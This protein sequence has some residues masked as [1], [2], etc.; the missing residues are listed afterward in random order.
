MVM[1]FGSARS[2]NIL[3][4]HTRT[5]PEIRVYA[6][7]LCIFSIAKL[8]FFFFF[9][10]LLKLILTEK[11]LFVNHLIK[12]CKEKSILF[13]KKI[14]LW[15]L[16]KKKKGLG[17]LYDRWIFKK[18]LLIN[19]KNFFSKFICQKA[20]YKILNNNIKKIFLI[21]F[22]NDSFLNIIFL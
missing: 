7:L 19:W 18:K 11:L 17:K 16:F 21:F 10:F 2:T 22:S 3:K 1:L 9:Y 20:L 4:T 15:L 12:S 13:I 5:H 8:F 6:H 14:F